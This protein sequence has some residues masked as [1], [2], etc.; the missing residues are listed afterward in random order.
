M[1][2]IFFNNYFLLASR[3]ILGMIFIFSGAE[4]I[5][6]SAAFAEA[7]SNYRMFPLV[8]VNLTAV[9]IPWLEL[10]SGLLLVFGI[11]TKENGYIILFLLV[12]FNILIFIAL[13]RGLN[14]DCGC[15][16]TARAE[17]IGISKILE[18]LI[19]TVIGIPLLFRESTLFSL[20]KHDRH[21]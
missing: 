3:I 8:V 2:K 18:N 19:L 4:K 21:K 10:I 20:N 1:K 6:G 15:F 12:I 16:G 9:V 7:V 5:S 14:I 13:A 11:A 17:Q